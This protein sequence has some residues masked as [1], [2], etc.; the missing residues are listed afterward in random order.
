MLFALVGAA[1]GQAFLTV[2]NNT[3]ATLA[4]FV[5]S[6]FQAQDMARPVTVPPVTA[7]RFAVEMG[8]FEL[9]VDAPKVGSD[10]G[11]RRQISFLRRG[12]HA[13]EIFPA[14]FGTTFLADRGNAAADGC[15]AM[16]GRWA[17]FVNGEVTIKPDGTH[18][19]GEITGTWSCS[20]NEVTMSWS[21]GYI[22]DLVLSAD[23]LSLT[24]VGHAKNPGGPQGYA[25]SGTKIE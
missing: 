21:H 7:V 18:Q 9:I 3:D 10:V 17:W 20:G 25:V 11:F 16:P 2:H 4:V 23:G 5:V 1:S 6:R 19:Q 8:L 15:D 14:D 13:I 12:E 24:G 22:D